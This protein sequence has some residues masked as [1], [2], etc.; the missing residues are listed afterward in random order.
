MAAFSLIL[1]PTDLSECSM[2]AFGVACA[3]AREGT[4]PVVVHVL[5][6]ALVASDSYLETLN[7]RLREFQAPDP[8]VTLEFHLKEGHAAAE[9]LRMA[10]EIGCDLIVMG[11]HGRTGLRRLLTGSVAEA[12]LRQARCPVL[13]VK[14]AP[15]EVSDSKRPPAAESS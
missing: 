13:V 5:E 7:D 14:S 10:E 11:T 12:V 2:A 9:I 6:E 8:G 1:H 3:L 15:A 4:R